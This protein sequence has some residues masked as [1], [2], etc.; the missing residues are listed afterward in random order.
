MD[1]GGSEY[2]PCWVLLN[3]NLLVLQKYGFLDQPSNCH[4]LKKILCTTNL[5]GIPLILLLKNALICCDLYC[6]GW[7][8]S[9]ALDLYF[10]GVQLEC[11]VRHQLGWQTSHALPQFLQANV[12]IVPRVSHSHFLQN[13]LQ[14]ISHCTFQCYI[15]SIMK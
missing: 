8:R 10:R 5:I 14:V 13:P 4:I 7:S 6:T 15:D 9:D 1:S 3:T 2:V 12:R 11:C